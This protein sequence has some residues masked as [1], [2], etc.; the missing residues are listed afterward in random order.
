MKYFD[1]N[2]ECISYLPCQK[3]VVKSTP[4]WSK[5]TSS[6]LV[7]SQHFI[8]ASEKNLEHGINDNLSSIENIDVGASSIS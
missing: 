6:S 3:L 7:S 2:I 4:K 8:D 1:D 5:T